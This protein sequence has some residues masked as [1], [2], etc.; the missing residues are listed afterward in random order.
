MKIKLNKIYVRRLKLPRVKIIE[1]D[2]SS[3]YRPAWIFIKGLPKRTAFVEVRLDDI[4]Q[5]YRV[6][7]STRIPLFLPANYTYEEL[8]KFYNKFSKVY[9][10]FV[11]KNNIP[12]TQFLIGRLKLSKTAKILDLGAGTGLASEALVSA[13]YKNITL[14]D[15]SQKMLAL[16]RRKRALKNCRFVRQDVRKLKIKDKFELIISVFSFGYGAYYKPEEMP[17]LWKL[18]AG[19]LKKGGTIALFGNYYEP[20]T[21]LFKKTSAGFYNIVGKYYTAYYIG[22]KR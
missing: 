1:Y 4:P 22:V 9:D 10:K 18:V 15:Y 11:E 13:G 7:I 5:Q 3:K 8:R 20:P 14:L 21:T 19:H 17:R 2:K 16:A 6:W 12:A